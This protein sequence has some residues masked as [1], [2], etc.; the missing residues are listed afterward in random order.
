MP[1]ST[2]AADSI[3]GDVISVYTRTQAIADGVL[4]DVSEMAREA[5]FKFPT[6]V[7]SSVW[8]RCVVLP[9]GCE[10]FQD[11]SGRLWDVLWMA[12]IAAR[13]NKGTDRVTFKLNVAT[14]REHL[15]ERAPL[16]ELVLHIGPGDT[17]EPVLTIMFP[18]DD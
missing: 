12:S 15:G 4:V 9:P 5:G 16:V 7:T 3:F 6:A 2:T 14:D 17:A 8:E 13:R 18:E 10:G 11:Q 1:A